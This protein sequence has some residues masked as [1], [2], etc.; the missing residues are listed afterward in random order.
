M[1]EVAIPSVASHETLGF[2]AAS[3]ILQEVSWMTTTVR[4]SLILDRMPLGRVLSRRRTRSLAIFARRDADISVG[5]LRGTLAAVTD[6]AHDTI[7][8]SNNSGHC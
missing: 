8:I 1:V 5:L 4:T 2:S 6:D 7:R 3:P